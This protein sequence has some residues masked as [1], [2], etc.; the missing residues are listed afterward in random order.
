MTVR[1]KGAPGDAAAVRKFAIRHQRRFM[2]WLIRFASDD[3]A[4][5][6]DRQWNDCRRSVTTLESLG[7]T[8]RGGL[9]A[10]MRQRNNDGP[11]R[12][13]ELA[14]VQVQLRTAF[15]K[16]TAPAAPNAVR[17]AY[18]PADGIKHIG[19]TAWRGEVARFDDARW[20]ASFYGMAAHLLEKFA[21]DLRRCEECRAVFLRNKRQQYCSSRC[22]Q[23]VRS[24]KHYAAHSEEVLDRRHDAHYAAK[25][26]RQKNVRELPRRP[27]RNANSR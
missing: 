24:R 12:N 27:R 9:V 25:R 5:Y 15:D 11:P 22:S 1:P 18:F 14:N 8:Q 23:R 4:T 10:L 17:S 3:L 16:L 19:V 13:D 6:T 2:E 26:K 20:P 21:A 7:S